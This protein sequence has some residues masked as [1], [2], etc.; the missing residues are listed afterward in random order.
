M[1]PVG[2]EIHRDALGP[3]LEGRL[4]MD[5]ALERA[6]PPLRQFMQR[7]TREKDLALFVRASGAARPARFEDVPTRA[8]VPA[9][10]LSELATAFRIGFVIFLPFLV[11]DMVVAT[12][13]LSMG[14]F[15][16][17]PVVVSMPLKVLLFVLVD[18]WNL[19]VGSLL[20]TF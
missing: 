10:I 20:R 15:Q 6:M 9:F 14:T 5:E 4:G 3:A 2:E 7:Y 19:V 12:V 1:S 13:L 8:L 11:I 17:P 18:G 16:M